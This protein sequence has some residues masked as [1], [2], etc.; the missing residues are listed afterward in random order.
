MPQIETTSEEMGG[1]TSHVIPDVSSNAIKTSEEEVITSVKILDTSDVPV[2]PVVSEVKAMQSLIEPSVQ[3]PLKNIQVFEGRTARLD[4]VIIGQPEPEVS[5]SNVLRMFGPVLEAYSNMFFHD[6]MKYNRFNFLY[7]FISIINY[8]KKNF[9][10]Y[11]IQFCTGFLSQSRY[12]QIGVTRNKKKKQKRV[13]FNMLVAPSRT[14]IKY[15]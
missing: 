14:G 2:E 13:F 7:I 10:L 5:K 15:F 9:L 6:K 8:S 4:C 12:F 1:R 11:L 3:L